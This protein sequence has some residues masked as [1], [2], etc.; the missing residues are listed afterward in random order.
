MKKKQRSNKKTIY[1]PSPEAR[2]RYPDAGDWPIKL[3]ECPTCGAD[4]FNPCIDKRGRKLGEGRYHRARIDAA[5]RER[6]IE[7]LRRDF[8]K[9]LVT[10]LDLAMDPEELSGFII[11]LAN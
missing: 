1:K 7:E 2:E 4:I 3:E 8:D 5:N 11:L 6:G 9:L 10:G